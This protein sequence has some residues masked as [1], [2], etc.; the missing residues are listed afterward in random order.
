MGQDRRPPRQELAAVAHDRELQRMLFDAGLA[1]HLFPRLP[2]GGRA[3]PPTT[4]K[5]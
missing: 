1:G 5:F 3:S 2:Y 4:R